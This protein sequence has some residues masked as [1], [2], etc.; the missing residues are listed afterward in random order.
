MNLDKDCVFK[1][2]LNIEESRD[3]DWFLHE[4]LLKNVPSKFSD[5]CKMIFSKM[6]EGY[7]EVM[8]INYLQEKTCKDSRKAHDVNF[9]SSKNTDSPFKGCNC[10]AYDSSQTKSKQPLSYELA[11]F[12]SPSHFS[13]ASYSTPGIA[14][15]TARDKAKFFLSKNSASTTTFT[16]EST[17]EDVQKPLS[18]KIKIVSLH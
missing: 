6:K 2:L 3:L 11:V 14:G 9:E 18:V 4:A 8:A 15:N 16:V 12:N 7:S 13:I 5:S 17:N 10:G 1:D